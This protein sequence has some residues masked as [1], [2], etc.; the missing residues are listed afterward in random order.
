[1]PFA[2]RKR[3]R[4]RLAGAMLCLAAA[5]LSGCLY[6]THHFNSGRILEP[7]QTAV[8]FGYGRA[9]LY[10]QVCPDGTVRYRPDTT[11]FTCYPENWYNRADW[12]PGDSTTPPLV[13]M[14]VVTQTLPK[15]SLSYRLGVR[16][17]WGPF[18]GVELGWQVEAPTNPATVEFDLKF[19]LPMPRKIP[20]VHS[21]SAGW[22]VGMW[23]DNSYFLEYAASHAFGPNALYGNYRFTWLA[24]QP[25]DIQTSFD[26]WKFRSYR[27]AI[28]QCAFGFYWKWPDVVMLPDYVSPQVDFTFPIRAPFGGADPSL[29]DAYQMDFNL[30]FGWNF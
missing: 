21:L 20:V 6:T 11:H 28:N 8:T 26:T 5:Q 30:G 9:K 18:T 27:Q 29:L 25:E 19:G 13:P 17:A 3:N 1:L 16:G 14:E 4:N 23:A 12:T 7:G 10:D 2:M 24:T 15:F 22:G